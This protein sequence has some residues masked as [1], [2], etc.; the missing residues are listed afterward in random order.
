MKFPIV[1]DKQLCKHDWVGDDDCPYCRAEEVETRLTLLRGWLDTCEENYEKLEETCD[2]V[3]DDNKLLRKQL[4][5]R[6]APV[7][8]VEHPEVNKW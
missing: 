7:K 4:A 8:R 3:K 2:T 5:C 6:Y 1:R